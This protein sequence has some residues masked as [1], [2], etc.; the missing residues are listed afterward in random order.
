ML[1]APSESN[2]NRREEGD[3]FILIIALKTEGELIYV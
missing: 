3:I 2:R 1:Y